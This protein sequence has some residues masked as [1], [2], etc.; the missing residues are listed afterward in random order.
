MWT[1]LKKLKIQRVYEKKKK[2]TWENNVG[3]KKIS[4]R[5]KQ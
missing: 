5:K 1:K 2:P 3:H 4:S